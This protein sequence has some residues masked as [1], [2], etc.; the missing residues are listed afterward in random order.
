MSDRGNPHVVAHRARVAAPRARLGAVLTATIGLLVS[1]TTSALLPSPVQA[2]SGIK[3]TKEDAMKSDSADQWLT[4]TVKGIREE[5]RYKSSAPNE[6]AGAFIGQ[7]FSTTLQGL[8]ERGDMRAGCPYAAAVVAAGAVADFEQFGTG[9]VGAVVTTVKGAVDLAK[10]VYDTGKAVATGGGSTI[11]EKVA[12]KAKDTLVDTAKDVAKDA[13][14]ETGKDVVAGKPADP[15]GKIHDAMEKKGE[16]A[17]EFIETIKDLFK[18]GPMIF[19]YS[20]TKSGCNI[21]TLWIWDG[22]QIDLYVRGTCDCKAKDAFVGPNNQKPELTSFFFHLYAETT[23][24]KDGAGILKWNLGTVHLGEH[25]AQCGCPKPK[26]ATGNQPVPATECPTCIKLAKQIADLEKDIANS[27]HKEGLEAATVQELRR[28][29][30]EDNPNDDPKVK[31][32]KVKLDQ[33]KADTEKLRAELEKAK[34][35]KDECEKKCHS[36]IYPRFTREHYVSYSTDSTAYCTYTEAIVTTEDVTWID[37]Q[38]YGPGPSDSPQ[39]PVDPG[40]RPAPS[41]SD[42]PKVADQPAPGAPPPAPSTEKAASAPTPVATSVPPDKPA[43]TTETT[44]PSDTDTPSDIPDNVE[45]KATQAVLEGGP[46]GTPLEG[47]SIKLVAEKP[48]LPGAGD[49]A[50]LDTGYDKLPARC[51]TDSKG[52][53]TIHVDPDERPHYNLPLATKARPGNYQLALSRPRASGGVA[54][55]TGRKT[56][57]D[58]RLLASIGSKI[59]ASSFR[60]GS[61]TFTRFALEDKYGSDTRVADKLKEAYGSDYEEDLCQDKEPGPPVAVDLAGSSSAGSELPGTT[62]ELGRRRHGQR[63]SRW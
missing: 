57:V 58:V 25:A 59:T 2:E 42:L 38:T 45:V 49:R 60:I 14:K 20:G 47:Q 46:T 63:A 43:T 33:I 3:I 4:D 35:E 12:E 44:P 6:L 28:A 53:C 23:P 50:A 5:V 15:V 52:E 17:K 13:A 24:A 7:P 40:A 30:T 51:T 1:V 41:P 18:D 9:P 39:T 61:R 55:T 62:L 10:K 11:A 19:A 37:P 26:T 29:S 56:P 27:E 22:K 16:E 31:A 34:K 54:E 36:Y 8:T 21:V 48:D 32:E